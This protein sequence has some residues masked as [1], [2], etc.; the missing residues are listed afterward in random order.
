AIHRSRSIFESPREHWRCQDAG[1]SPGIDNAPPIERRRTAR[2]GRDTGNDPH[3]GR[4]RSAGRYHLGCRP[5]IGASTIM[6]RYRA[7][8]WPWV[9]LILAL[10][11]VGQEFLFKSL[12]ANPS[13]A[14]TS[15]R[16]L[17]MTIAATSIAL[18]LLPPRRPAYLLGFL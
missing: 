10:A 14:Q 9:G 6:M 2:C 1:N 15:Y 8:A 11:L 3:F 5:G 18:I 7:V 17:I 4:A 16:M 13:L 12:G